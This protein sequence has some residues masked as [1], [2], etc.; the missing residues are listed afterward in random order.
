MVHDLKILTNERQAVA[1]HV[2]V[3]SK[4]DK[5][6]HGREHPQFGASRKFCFRLPAKKP[7]GDFEAIRNPIDSAIRSVT[8]SWWVAR[9]VAAF[10]R[11]VA[12][13]GGVAQSARRSLL[14]G[15]PR[16]RV[17]MVHDLKIVT[18]ERQAVTFTF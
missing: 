3:D 7:T 16:S 5:R 15:R 8:I 18:N 2:F 6:N 11:P 4:G 13:I 10:S 12:Q 1:F 9:L 17:P 14:C